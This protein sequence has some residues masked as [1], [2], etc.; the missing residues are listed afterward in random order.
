MLVSQSGCAFG[1]TGEGG[2]GPR[3]EEASVLGFPAYFGIMGSRDPTN[4]KFQVQTVWK[5][6]AYPTRYVATARSG[7]SCGYPFKV[8]TEYVV[9]SLGWHVSLCSRTRPLSEATRYVADLGPGA[10]PSFWYRAALSL[11]VLLLTVGY[12]WL[13]RRQRHSARR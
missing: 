4:V 1:G 3:R 11:L 6:A 8:G 2:G 7:A 13:G 12:S 5:G 10:L 9:C